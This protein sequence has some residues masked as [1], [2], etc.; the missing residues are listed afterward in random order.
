MI[1]RFLAKRALRFV[2]VGLLNAMVSFGLLNFAFYVLHQSKI[3]SS[4]ISTTCALLLSF[5]LNRHFVFANK[6]ERV[7]R[8]LPTFILVTVTGTLGVLNFVYIVSL[9]IIRGH[10]LPIIHMI[11]SLT[12]LSVTRSFVDINVSTVI[13]AAVAM[14]WNYN[15]YKWFVFKEQKNIPTDVQITV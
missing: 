3:M 4:I 11:N 2:L 5:V 6:T 10:E 1:H 13:G 8:Q 12:P 9:G 15:G 7:R 14:A